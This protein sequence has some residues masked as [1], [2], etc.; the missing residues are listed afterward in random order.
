MKMKKPN[1]ITD[2]WYLLSKLNEAA[3]TDKKLYMEGC[4]AQ[5][6]KKN[7]NGRIYPLPIMAKAVSDYNRMYGVGNRRI[8]ELNH[9]DHLEVNPERAAI[10]IDSLEMDGNDVMGK[11]LV[12]ENIP[13]GQIVGGLMRND[14][15]L[16]VSTRGTGE[17]EFSGNTAIIKDGFALRAI[18]VVFSPSGID[19][20]VSA[21]EEGEDFVSNNDNISEQGLDSLQYLIKRNDMKQINETLGALARGFKI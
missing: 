1:I 12:M 15:T 7:R 13:A 17:V 5:A 20:F 9:P 11:A 18:D 3:K 21:V 16:G 2:T 10:R 4:F 14:I 19:C 6:E 8:G